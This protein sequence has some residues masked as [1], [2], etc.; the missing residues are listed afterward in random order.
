[1]VDDVNSEYIKPKNLM[2]LI[3]I[4]LLFLA[5]AYIYIVIP[6]WA[7]GLNYGFSVSS[8][9]LEEHVVFLS[10]VD[11]PRSAEH[12]H[13]L[14]TAADYIQKQWEQLGLDV[15]RQ[16]FMVDGIE[17][18]NI[19]AELGS[20]EAPLA[21]IGAH[22][23]VCGD[24]PGADDNASAV[25]G[26]LE[27]SRVLLAHQEELSYRF[28]LVAYALEEP[29]HFATEFMG[30]AV[31]AASLSQEGQQ[32]EF[33]VSL[34][35]LG[36]FS[37]QPG[38]QQYPL[39]GMSLLYPSKGDFIALISDNSSR[40]MLKN[41]KKS[42]AAVSKVPIVSMCAP[43]QVV[44]ID[45][46]DHRN[47]WQ[48]GVPAMMLTDTAFFRNPNYHQVTDTPD[49]LDYERMAF[50]VEAFAWAMMNLEK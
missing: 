13:S 45:F 37:D 42:M 39:P 10:T 30:S 22:Y 50:V 15:S 25:A 16:T 20:P 29:P 7:R 32:P 5:L 8:Q 17:Y 24:Q 3:V 48:Y 1:M 47:Y 27:L 40:N 31:H 35:M 14:N 36:Y 23:D 41:I 18:H 26:L 19:I 4:S 49:T 6:V 11:P 38:S 28:V 43:R 34:E 9:H 33:M 46:S 2:T 44:G 12:P 21:V